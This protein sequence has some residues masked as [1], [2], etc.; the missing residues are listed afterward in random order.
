MEYKW[1]AARR[2]KMCKRIVVFAPFVPFCGHF[3]FTVCSPSCGLLSKYMRRA[4]AN[5]FAPDEA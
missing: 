3:V 2:R 4:A 5:D 1:V